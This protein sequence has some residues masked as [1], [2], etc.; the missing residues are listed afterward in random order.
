MQMQ[1]PSH[2]PSHENAGATTRA[3][4]VSGP[5]MKMLGPWYRTAQ[6]G[7]VPGMVRHWDSARS[8]F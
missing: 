3:Y 8:W 2:V 1:G 5:R 6:L 4:A 7:R